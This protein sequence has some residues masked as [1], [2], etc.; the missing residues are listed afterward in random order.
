MHSFSIVFLCT[1]LIV[2][3]NRYLFKEIFL[4]IYCFFKKNGIAQ[5]FYSCQISR[6]KL[7]HLRKVTRKIFALLKSKSYLSRLEDI[8]RHAT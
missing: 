1:I 5:T 2:L 6:L 3:P 8:A 7:I 4:E